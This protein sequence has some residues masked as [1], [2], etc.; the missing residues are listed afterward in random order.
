[1]AQINKSGGGERNLFSPFLCCCIWQ[2]IFV[3]ACCFRP[4][5]LVLAGDKNCETHFSP[6][7]QKKIFF[8]I[9]KTLHLEIEN[10]CL[11]VCWFGCYVAE[12]NEITC[13]LPLKALNLITESISVRP[14]ISPNATYH[15]FFVQVEYKGKPAALSPS[16]VRE[17]GESLLQT[18]TVQAS[19]RCDRVYESA[20]CDSSSFPFYSFTCRNITKTKPEKILPPSSSALYK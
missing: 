19:L 5:R 11:A 20:D 1:M 17:A 3:V 15:Y 13:S 18:E 10:E 8:L 4:P 16:P 6:S 14:S 12:E 7:Q 9:C 2:I